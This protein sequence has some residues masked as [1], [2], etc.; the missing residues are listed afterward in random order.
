[1][2]YLQYCKFAMYPFGMLKNAAV[3]FLCPA[4]CCQGV[5]I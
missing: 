3:D 1:M 2:D 4:I 5:N